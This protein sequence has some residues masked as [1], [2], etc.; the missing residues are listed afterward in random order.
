MIVIDEHR[1]QVFDGDSFNHLFSIGSDQQGNQS[2]QFNDP[3]G[4]DCNPQGDMIVADT[5][6]HRMQIF[7]VKGKHLH[8]FGS[9]GSNNNQFSYPH[10]VCVDVK[11]NRMFITDF[12]NNRLSVWSVDGSQVIHTFTVQQYPTGICIDPY[13]HHIV[14]SCYGSNDIKVFDVKNWELIQQFGSEGSQPGQFNDPYGV[15]I[16]D[17][18]VLIVVARF[19][20]LVQLF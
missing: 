20:F 15:C 10:D 8:S 9:Q 4:V 16:D 7:D 17:R 2:S 5:D 1:L 18:G 19:N 13:T 11:T 14:V 12:N 3:R 6:N